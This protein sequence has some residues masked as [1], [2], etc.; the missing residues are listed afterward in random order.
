MQGLVTLDFGNTNP[1]AGLFS[2]SGNEWKLNKVV[3]FTD[4]QDALSELKLTPDN[5]NFVLSEVK[6]RDAELTPYL[7]QGY[8]ITRVKEYWRGKMFAGMPVNYAQTLGEDRLIQ[9]FYLFKKYK[10]KSI[11]IDAGSYTTMDVLNEEGFRGGYIVPGLKNYF[12][13][14]DAGELLKGVER[15]TNLLMDL[16]RDTKSAMSASYQAF[17]ALLHN[18]IDQHKIQKVFL[19][20]GNMDYW[21]EILDDSKPSL[22]IKADPHLIHHSLFHWFTTQI[23]PL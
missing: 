18:L 11:I 15:E 22:E 3:A 9:A 13:S 1:H 12:S 21:K 5:T 8:L 17:G 10:T 23:E 6:N 2:K 19:T 20:G 16:P 7:N 14:F 4:L